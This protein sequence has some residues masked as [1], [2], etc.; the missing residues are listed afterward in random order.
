MEISSEYLRKVLQ[1]CI[2]AIGSY[3][4]DTFSASRECVTAQEA[5]DVLA[6]LMIGRL[7]DTD[8]IPGDLDG[9][10]I[11]EALEDVR[12]GNLSGFSCGVDR[13]SD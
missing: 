1:A 12:R 10:E 4:S 7:F 11:G 8:G 9:I 13:L 6:R 2:T 3:E 5:E